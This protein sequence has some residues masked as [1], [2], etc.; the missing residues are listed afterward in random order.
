MFQGLP[1]LKEIYG[2]PVIT[3]SNQ[4][5]ILLALIPYIIDNNVNDS[6]LLF[7][8]VINFLRSGGY[9]VRHTRKDFMNNEPMKYLFQIGSDLLF[10]VIKSSGVNTFVF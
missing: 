10:K 5:R 9:I 6:Y 3:D 7:G 4:L 1:S 2:S 8:N